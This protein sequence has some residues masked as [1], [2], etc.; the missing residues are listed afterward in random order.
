MPTL[1]CPSTQTLN[2]E[3]CATSATF[4]EK[5]AAGFTLI[6]FDCPSACVKFADA[7]ATPIEGT[8]NQ[9]PITGNPQ[10]KFSVDVTY[11]CKQKTKELQGLLEQIQSQIKGTAQLKKPVV[12]PQRPVQPKRPRRG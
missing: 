5:L 4:A 8:C 10:T 7:T 11:G 12:Q 2:V 3:F 9:D 1:K 6:S